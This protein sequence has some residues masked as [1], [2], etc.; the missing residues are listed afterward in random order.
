RFVL[1]AEADNQLLIDFENALSVDALV[2]YVRKREHIRLVEMFPGPENLCA[3]GPEGSFTHEV[4]I[5]FVRVVDAQD[6]SPGSGPFRVRE[7]EGKKPSGAL[8][9]AAPPQLWTTAAPGC[10][11]E[12]SGREQLITRKEDLKNAPSAKKIDVNSPARNFL[13]G[14]EWLFAKIYASP[15]NADRLLLEV[16]KPLIEKIMAAGEADSWFFIRYADPQWHLRLRFHGSP[17]TLTARVLPALWQALEEHRRQ[18]KIWR[19][20]LDTYERE[21]ERYGGLDGV[22]VAE[23]LFQID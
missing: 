6:F 20:Q 8:G 1:L 13:P 15:S 18:G 9:P 3:S 21:I 11:E 19:M 23:H 10:A 12:S 2:E 4:V 7:E 14:S 17:A 5:P 22:Q 16:I